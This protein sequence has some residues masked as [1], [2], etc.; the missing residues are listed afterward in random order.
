MHLTLSDLFLKMQ[1]QLDQ[2]QAVLDENLLIELVNRIRPKNPNDADEVKQRIHALIRILLL[3]PTSAIL[4]Q[5][6]LLK[7]ISQYK[8]ISLY[9]DSGILSLDGFWNQL[10]QRLGAHFLPLVEDGQQLK[11]LIGKVF[12]Q[13]NDYEWLDL[14]DNQDWTTLF[15]LLAESQ[16]NTIE[17]QVSKNELIKAITV[18]SYRIS[19]IG[20][21]PEFIN[22]QPD[23]IEYESPFLVQNRDIIEFIEKYKKQIEDQDAVVVLPPPDASQAFV[24]LD[25]CRD[26]V[27]KIRRATKRIGVSISLTYLL[28]LLEQSLDRIELLLTLLA[29][30]TEARY[31]ALGELIIDLTKAHYDSKSVRHLLNST[32]EL[33]ALQVTENASRTGEHYVSTDKAGF[34]GMYKAAAGA[35]VI[36]AIMASLK[37]LTARLVLAPLMQAFLFSMN[38]SLGFLLIHVLHFTV[39]T[40]QP[41][42]T[43]A[44][45]ATT[46]QQQKGSKTAQIAELAALIINI[47]RTQFIA[48]LGNISIAIPTAALITFL[49][50]YNLGEPLLNH[51]KSAK[52]LHSLNPF[53]SLAVPHAAIAGVCLFLSGL[54]AGYF[55][56][57]AVYRKVGP[58][59]RQHPRLKRWMGQKRL[60]KF[61][62][63]IETNLGALAGNFLFGIML[64]SM[65]TIGFILGLPLDI[66]HIAFASANF[67]QGL[68]TIGNPD[69]GLIIVS[70]LG[71]LLIGLTNLFVSFTLTII[72]ALRAR[73]VRFAQWKPLAKLVMTHFLTRPSDFFWPPKQPVEVEEQPK[74][75]SSSH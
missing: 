23:I 58:R 17:K 49:W 18:L 37:I 28:S 16:S 48:I 10:G 32:S 8:Q 21:Y 65:G 55:D 72:V 62:S 47:I 4:L 3:T 40:K 35:G 61:A 39:A 43:A 50:Q 25:Q 7:L 44:A 66:R 45:L 13:E 57:L 34:F 26:V 41:A 64:G 75:A 2:P 68:M 59:L 74:N 38:Y 60:D 20:L 14:I 54:I 69:I 42:M 73:R 51:A 29:S 63:Y 71:V 33:I 27:L 15:N 31:T 19:G 30:K 70:F 56:N 67:I 36:I 12:H 53:T 52:I 24:M 1:E 9:A 6:F 46:V 11:T 5:N 22:A